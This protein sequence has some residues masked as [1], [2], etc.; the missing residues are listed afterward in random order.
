[1]QTQLNIQT[2]V[3]ILSSS[4][5]LMRSMSKATIV[6]TF[7]AYFAFFANAQKLL[8]GEYEPGLKLAFDPVSETVTAYF[9][10]YGG[11]DENSQRPQFSCIF[12]I[13]GPLHSN[14]ATIRSYYPGDPSDQYID[15]KLEIIDS[16]NIRI[17]LSGEHPGCWNVMHFSEDPAEFSLSK[18]IPWIQVAYVTADKSYFHSETA[19]AKKLKSYLIKNDVVYIEQRQ[20]DWVLCNFYG[21]RRTKGW[22]RRSDVKEAGQP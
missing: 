15:G 20:A 2:F 1:M 18:A 13:E 4:G 12:F 6:L 7:M 5:P 22:L 10:S 16:Q 9:E 11:W 3:N 21:K 14:Q 17:L 8:S 19:V